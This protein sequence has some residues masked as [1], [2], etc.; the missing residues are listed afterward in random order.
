MFIDPVPKPIPN[1]IAREPRHF[2]RHW[3]R[4]AIPVLV[5]IAM[6]VG[7]A[8]QIPQ[9]VWVAI[10]GCLVVLLIGSLQLGGL[11]I[12]RDGLAWYVL[13]PQWTYREIPWDAVLE[14]RERTFGMYPMRLILREGRY[15]P[16]FW[17]TPNPERTIEVQIWPSG[18]TGGHGIYEA[19][20]QFWSPPQPKTDHTKEFRTELP[21]EPASAN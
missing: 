1:F 10:V 5:G 15:E 12:S 6:F 21:N 17:G 11:I 9:G 20:R 14:I 8:I 16:W 2:R 13:R 3:W 19:M 18:F 7:F 4:A